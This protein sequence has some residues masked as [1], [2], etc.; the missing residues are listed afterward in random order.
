MTDP[1]DSNSIADLSWYKTLCTGF[2]NIGLDG[3]ALCIE[4]GIYSAV[5]DQ[6]PAGGLSDAMSVAFEIA[7]ARTGDPHIGLRMARHPRKSVV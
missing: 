5:V 3:A 1:M 4:A 6:L 7:V 2:N